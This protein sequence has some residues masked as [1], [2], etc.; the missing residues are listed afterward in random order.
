[1]PR[2]FQKSKLY[3]AERRHSLFPRA[4]WERASNRDGYRAAPAEDEMNVEEMQAFVNDILRT[5]W[6]KN[7]YAL[8]WVT[9]KDG[10]GRRKAGGDYWGRC[11]KMPRWSRRPIV[12]L[13]ELVHVLLNPRIHPY[14]GE[15]FCGWYLALVRRFISEDA[16]KE[17]RQHMQDVG[18]KVGAMPKPKHA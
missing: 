2:D 1:M 9:V 16:Y 18:V 15:E 12:V 5:R 14:H 8:N 4:E 17:L 7:R 11:I 3:E 13:H 10:R 6:F